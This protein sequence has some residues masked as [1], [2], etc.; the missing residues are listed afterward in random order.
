[1]LFRVA[2]ALFSLLLIL[3]LPSSGHVGRDLLGKVPRMTVERVPIDWHDPTRTR[4]GAL[5]YLGGIR[6]KGPDLAFG[7]F[8][9]MQVEGDRFTLL[10]DGGNFIRFRMGADWTPRA[11]AFGDL[12]DGPGTGWLKSDRDSESLTTDA[13]TGQ[14]WVGFERYN[15]IWRYDADL[16]RAERSARPPAMQ[17]WSE[18]GGPESMVRLADGQFIVLSETSRPK[19]SRIGR[20]ALLFPGD[21]TAPG[22]TPIRF[23]YMPPDERYD[24]SDAVQLPDGR[25]IVLNRRFSVSGLFTARLTLVDPRAIRPGAVVRGIEIAAL[26]PPL[27]HDNYEA[28]AVTREGKD[29]ILWIASDDNQQFWEWSLL[30][31]FRIEFAKR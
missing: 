11:L 14:T 21:P 2:T 6:L 28:L 31:K 18:N 5:T 7:G 12:P 3:M 9:S 24:P 29:T 15:A 23:V 27:L 10:S 16:T 25:L 1:M 20:E 17:G 13:A 19:G 30:L 22:S 26:A 4:V 8:S